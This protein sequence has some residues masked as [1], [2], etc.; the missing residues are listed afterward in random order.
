MPLKRRFPQTGSRVSSKRPNKNLPKA[1]KT[2]LWNLYNNSL[3][4]FGSKTNYIKQAKEELGVNEVDA[5]KYLH[6]INAYTKFRKR[7]R[8]F[9]R[10]SARAASKD[11]IWCADLAF[12]DKLAEY[13][14]NY[15]YLLLIIDIFSR[16]IHV[17]PMEN[18][19]ASSARTAFLTCVLQNGNKTPKKLWVDRGTEFR[20]Q[21]ADTCEN[22]NIEIYS[23]N[24]DTKAAYAE[25]AI[26]SLKRII[27]RYFEFAKTKRYIDQLPKFVD[28]MNSRQHST[29]KKAPKDVRNKDFLMVLYG[30]PRGSKVSVMTKSPKYSV[31]E[32]VRISAKDEV[33]R[34]GYLQ[35]FTTEVFKIDRVTR[36]PIITYTLR[37]KNKNIIQGKFY[38]KELV[39]VIHMA[40]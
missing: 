2:R 40:Q 31:G 39:K 26:Q 8:N 7:T 33:F 32:N 19:N 37:D 6:S 11:E 34:K 18:K 21:F 16:F 29:L 38:E 5:E 1:T 4:A 20:G 17:A 27:H 24:S 15:K 3:A 35:T 12:L 14:D 23:T 25:R 28:I 13:N 22:L 30:H 36:G 10:L 9:K